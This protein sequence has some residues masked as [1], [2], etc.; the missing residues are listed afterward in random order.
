VIDISDEGSLI[1]QTNQG[2]QNFS[3]GEVVLNKDWNN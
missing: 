3:S 1:L 2:Q